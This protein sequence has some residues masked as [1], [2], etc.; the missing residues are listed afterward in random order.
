[1]L[2][3]EI[4]ASLAGRLEYPEATAFVPRDLADGGL[5][6][7]YKRAGTH[8][9][10][11]GEDGSVELIRPRTIRPQHI[12]AALAIAALV[13]WAMSRNGSPRPVA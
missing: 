1:V 6:E 8:V 13:L 12:I 4:E 10:V 5:L 7:R 2:D 3:R 9:G 11:V